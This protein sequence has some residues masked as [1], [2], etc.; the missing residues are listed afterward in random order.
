M[1]VDECGND[2]S[3]CRGGRCINTPG[4][5][6]CEC[7]LGL[8]LVTNAFFYFACRPNVIHFHA[9]D[10]KVEENF[11]DLKHIK[12]VLVTRPVTRTR[13]HRG[14]QALQGHRR[15]FHQQRSLLQRSL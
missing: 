4:S 11:D 15:V 9:G 10:L 6:V 1:D 8:G 13:A 7:P 3:L 12:D 14:R 2:P 5:F